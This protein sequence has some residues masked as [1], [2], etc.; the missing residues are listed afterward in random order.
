MEDFV[1]NV[2]YGYGGLYQSLLKQT[3]T[4]TI[5]V[6]M[7]KHSF[8]HTCSVFFPVEASL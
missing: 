7:A 8:L 1:D 2:C 5:M 6:T 3:H 4:D